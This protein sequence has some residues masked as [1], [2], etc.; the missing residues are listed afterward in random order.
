MA[1][2][3]LCVTIS[4]CL[5]EARLVSHPNRKCPYSGRYRLVFTRWLPTEAKKFFFIPETRRKEVYFYVFFARTRWRGCTLCCTL[6]T[7]AW[8]GGHRVHKGSSPSLSE[9]LSSHYWA[10]QISFSSWTEVKSTF[11]PCQMCSEEWKNAPSSQTPL[12]A[13]STRKP[14]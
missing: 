10:R 1:C 14:A 11:R 8:Q 13:V 5:F 9:L 4:I 3:G 7:S 2:T 6:H 12:G